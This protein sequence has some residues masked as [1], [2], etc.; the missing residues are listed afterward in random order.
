MLNPN[1]NPNRNPNPNPN[2]NPNLLR[3]KAGVGGV[4]VLAV[5]KVD[6]PDGA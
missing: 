6:Q 5:A 4:D 2:R 3:H 1:P